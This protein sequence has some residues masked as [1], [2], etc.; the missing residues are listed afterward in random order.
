MSNIKIYII[1][2]GQTEQTFVRDIFAPDMAAKGIFC[3]PILI[4]KTGHKG[5]DVRFDR[6][7]I[8]IRNSLKY[9]SNNYVSTMF[10]YF[11]IN[12]NWP[13]LQ[14]LKQRI[15]KGTT[16]S[17]T[18]KA[19]FLEKATLTEIINLFPDCNAEKRF[20]PYISMHEFEALLFSDAD[21]LAEKLKV[22]VDIIK[23]I[24]DE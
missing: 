3:Y 14:K 8:N 20:I 11:G 16:F 12:K 23:K 15:Q 2:E 19:N 6:A 4:G 17:A 22:E 13:G 24:L 5:G 9:R 10:D 21:I 1:I 7:K 18:E